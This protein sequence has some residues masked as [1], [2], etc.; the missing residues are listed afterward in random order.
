MFNLEEFKAGVPAVDR[1][2]NKYVY[3]GVNPCLDEQLAI[4]V[5]SENHYIKTISFE[6]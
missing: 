4:S 1:D 5:R 6:V 2:G 3:I